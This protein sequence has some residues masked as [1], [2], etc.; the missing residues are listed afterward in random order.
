[1]RGGARLAAVLLTVACAGAC[2]LFTD[3]DGLDG[4]GSSSG[5]QQPNDGGRDG[6]LATIDGPNNNNN[7]DS[8]GGDSG[9]PP[10]QRALVVVGGFK[11][12]DAGG[13]VELKSGASAL[14]GANGAIGSF[15]EAPISGLAGAYDVRVVSHAGR[16][17]AV[18]E[19]T[20]YVGLVDKNNGSV[21]WS[22]QSSPGRD[23]TC[24]AVSGGSVYALGGNTGGT[25][26]PD[27][28]VSAAAPPLNWTA[29]RALP[30]ERQLHGCAATETHVYVVAGKNKDGAHQKTVF[31]AKRESA[32]G[33]LGTWQPTTPLPAEAYWPRV[34]VAGGRLWVLGA[35]WD[36]PANAETV[37]SAAINADGTVGPWGNG[38]PLPMRRWDSAAAVNGNDLYIIS[39][40]E[41]GDSKPSTSIWT[42]KLTDQ[43]GSMTP[44]ITA[45][46]TLPVARV[47]HGA[48]FVS[49][50]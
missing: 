11:V 44:W 41:G 22:V 32:N 46:I 36:P 6:P 25:V 40:G 47:R 31:V 20:T 4:A 14:V 23:G 37:Y 42:S 12:D 16:V 3:L 10:E 17:L 50:P 7:N 38:A 2:S 28:S 8:G 27:V 15:N 43:N 1:V 39:G 34:V 35:E 18:A 33:A 48:T 9:G 24:V 29:T 30:I 19:Q 45:P 21:V 5:S 49:I 26:S 13:N